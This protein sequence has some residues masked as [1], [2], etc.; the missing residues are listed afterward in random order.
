M[1]RFHCLQHVHFETPGNMEA[2]IK[3]R[4]H[5]IS[6]TH[7]FKDARLPSLN[8]FDAIMIMGG[9]MSVHDEHA[10]PWLKKEKEFIAMAIKAN[11]KILGI[12]LGAQLIATVLGAKVYNS[13]E[14]EIGFMPVH[15]TENAYQNKLFKGFKAEEMVLHWH[16]ETF[17][18]PEGAILLA[19]TE[20]CT[21]QAFAIGKNI[22]GLQFHLEVTHEILRN[23][24]KHEGH[25]L[26]PAAF[27]HSGEKILKELGYLERN[28]TILFNLLDTFF[29]PSLKGQKALLR[30]G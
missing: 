21:N 25:E 3:Q 11:K 10:F 2:W 24:V 16:G 20:T 29:D 30:A 14:K 17:A 7:F 26:V 4:G 15:F 18:L 13:K 19:S 9:P 12:C 23:L 22:I 1:M 5:P 6:F 27:I 8:D 28:K